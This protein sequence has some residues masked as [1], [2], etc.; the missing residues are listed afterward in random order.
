[1][2]EMISG[3]LKESSLCDD[4]RSRLQKLNHMLYSIQCLELQTT[5]IPETIRLDI[6]RI[7]TENGLA[8]FHPF[9]LEHSADAIL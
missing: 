6:L 9:H 5:K 2:P 7:S 1:M 4:A 8:S 3:G